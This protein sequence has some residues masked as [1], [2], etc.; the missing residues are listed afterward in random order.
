MTRCKGILFSLLAFFVTLQPVVAQIP[1]NCFEIESI[2]VDACGVGT[3]EGLNE[4]VIFQVGPTALN[5]ANLS[6]TWP[7]T[8]NPWTGVCQNAGTTA[9]VTAI[10]GTITGCGRLVEPV[11]GVLPAGKR[12]VLF[13]SVSVDETLHSF[14]NLDDTLIAIFHCGNNTGGNFANTGAGIRTLT[15]DFSVPLGCS[16]VVSYDRSLLTGGNGASVNYCWNGSP[17]Y[18]NHGC[19]AP[20]VRVGTNAGIAQTVCIGSPVNLG[21]SALSCTHRVLWSGGTGTFSNPNSLSST[22]TPGPGETGVVTLTLTQFTSC[23]SA[24]ST[25]NINFTPPPSFSLGPD[26]AFCGSFSFPVGPGITGQSYAWS[27]GPTSQNITVTSPGT[28]ALTLTTAAGCVVADTISIGVSTLSSLGFPADDTICT[29]GSFFLFPSIVGSVYNWSNGANGN[30]ITVSSPGTYSLT[31]TTPTGCVGFD[32]FQLY[33]YPAVVADLGNDTTLCPGST[34]VLDADPQGN[35][36][37]AGFAWSTGAT[38]QAIAVGTTGSYAVTITSTALCEAIDTVQVTI[39]STIAIPLGPD[40]AI[41]AGASLLLDAGGSGV[42]YTW[43]TGANS[44]TITVNATGSYAVTVSY[45]LNCQGADTLNLV[46]NPN[47]TVNLGNDTLYCPATG[48]TLDAGPGNSY[49]WNTGA[50]TQTLPLTAGGTYS[51]TVT[52]SGN[53][54]AIDTV[55]VGQGMDPQ[56]SLGPNVQLC[57]GQSIVLDA[58][59]QATTYLWSTGATTQAITLNAA[60]TYWAVVTTTCGSDSSAT[61]VTVLPAGNADA[62]PDGTLCAGD[63]LTLAGA[64]ASAGSLGW[65]ASS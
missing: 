25:V 45:G 29:T 41:C 17:T 52:N 55:L 8:T 37:G 61:T 60:G 2:L 64:Q 4:M 50:M 43:S 33:N 27:N 38:T 13:S 49:L 42:T 44:Q 5:A 32:S 12:V 56:V 21:G 35:Y 51:V 30:S 47:P 28:Y 31:L 10:N 19:S 23:S 62:G 39:N 59:T 3:L 7:N 63:T 11:G 20:F 54:I 53:C 22:Y 48:L 24:S 6:V 14:A 18:V 57:P 26:T 65:T 58:G 36:P 16:D 9:K 40:T 34:L 46:V 1:T 15:M